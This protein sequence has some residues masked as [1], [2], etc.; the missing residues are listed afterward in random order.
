MIGEGVLFRSDR[1]FMKRDDSSGTDIM[2]GPNSSFYFG[3]GY[4]REYVINHNLGYVPFFRAFYEPYGD[5]HLYPVVQD[6]SWHL[7]PV[8]NSFTDFTETAPTI[9]A[10]A[11][12]VNLTLTLYFTDNS[13][14]AV[15]YPIYWVIYKDFGLEAS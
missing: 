1:N 7:K 4:I 6:S 2:L 10:E 11:D 3:N 8:I 5:G 13:K 9:A 15:E 12:E 14:A